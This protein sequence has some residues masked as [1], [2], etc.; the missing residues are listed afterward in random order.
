M[1]RADAA[2]AECPMGTMRDDAINERALD[3]TDVHRFQSTRHPK[4]ARDEPVVLASQWCLRPLQLHDGDEAHATMDD[5]HVSGTRVTAI[6]IDGAPVRT[7]GAAEEPVVLSSQ[8]CLRPLQQDNGAVQLHDGDEA[9]ATMDDGHVS[10][11]RATAIAIDGAPASTVGAAEEPVVLSSQLCLR[12]LQQDKGA[13][14]MQVGDRAHATM[15]DGHVS[16]TR[17]TAN[18]IAIAPAH[19]SQTGC[20]PADLVSQSSLREQPQGGQKEWQVGILGSSAARGTAHTSAETPAVR[21]SEPAPPMPELSD[22]IDSVSLTSLASRRQHFQSEQ[23]VHVCDRDAP[24]RWTAD[25]ASGQWSRNAKPG[26]S[27]A[28]RSARTVARGLTFACTATGCHALVDLRCARRQ[29]RSTGRQRLVPGDGCSSRVCA[30]FFRPGKVASR[31]GAMA[32]GLRAATRWLVRWPRRLDVQE[33]WVC[34]GEQ[35]HSAAD[36]AIAALTTTTRPRTPSQ[37]SQFSPRQIPQPQI[38]QPQIPQQQIPQQQIPQQHNPRQRP[39]NPSRAAICKGQGLRLRGGGSTQGAE[40]FACTQQAA[41]DDFEEAP[42]LLRVIGGEPCAWQTV[43]MPSEGASLLIGRGASGLDLADGRL[44]SAG[45]SLVHSQH[46]SIHQVEGAYFLEILG[47]QQYTFVN[48][49]PYRVI[50]TVWQQHTPGRI[51]LAD[52]DTLRFGGSVQGADSGYS[53]FIYVVDAPLAAQPDRTSDPLPAMPAALPRPKAERRTLKPMLPPPPRSLA[54]PAAEPTAVAASSPATTGNTL[55]IAAPSPGPSPLASTAFPSALDAAASP[56]LAA[57]P[58][59][60]I[61]AAVTTDAVGSPAA[62]ATSTAS[63]YGSFDITAAVE[64]FACPAA[65]AAPHTTDAATIRPTADAAT[66]ATYPDANAA[67]D[68]PQASS[69]GTAELSMAFPVEAVARV[70]GSGG[71]SIRRIRHESGARVETGPRPPAG[72]RE[73]GVSFSGTEAQVALAVCMAVEASGVDTAAARAAQEQAGITMR[74]RIAATPLPPAATK[75]P[76]AA[77]P[78]PSAAVSPSSTAVSAAAVLPAAAP[79]A[80]PTGTHAVATAAAP[81]PASLVPM[82]GE[83]IQLDSTPKGRTQLGGGL[84]DAP[85]VIGSYAFVVCGRDGMFHLRTSL[86]AVVSYIPAAAAAGGAAAAVPLRDGEQ[87]VLHNGDRLLV[88]SPPSLEVLCTVPQR[89]AH[90]ATAEP[91]QPQP[92]AGG[93]ASHVADAAELAH[94][95]ARTAEVTQRLT[96]GKSGRERQESLRAVRAAHEAFVGVALGAAAPSQQQQQHAVQAAAGKLKKVVVDTAKKRRREAVTH[97]HDVAK[98]QRR[99]AGVERQHA[100]GAPRPSK[101]ERQHAGKTAVRKVRRVEGDAQRM[102][103]SSGHGSGRGAAAAAA[104]RGHMNK[105]KGKGKGG[106]S[107]GGGHSGGRGFRGGRGH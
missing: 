86:P 68:A 37:T 46:A 4:H 93:A 74:K 53:D 11:T 19:R 43:D 35:T 34:S 26:M 6:A 21:A 76:A 22:D 28:A 9:H 47:Q 41:D 16:G 57:A 5:G 101:R 67:T 95:A 84:L 31:Q 36:A 92:I 91:P 14:Q 85:G 83:P 70:I 66:A 81:A 1:E 10:G 30:A 12:P 27:D 13:V 107:K 2:A 90:Q 88:G 98:A 3:G 72:Q 94:L 33:V 71:S 105:G 77:P 89:A 45:G 15:D 56:A 23:L 97:E 59:G 55:D 42:Q 49:M 18:A 87:R 75:A 39:R 60:T 69:Q 8:L 61:A 104:A 82:G 103:R 73:Q 40:D 38:P 17:A 79:I 44:G 7:V 106:S 54:S 80:P 50:R 48:E 102:A 52:G 62:E 63:T 24:A 25:R 58:V 100:R 64:P 51:H 65:A 78:P 96:A 29:A 32:A 20:E 99:E